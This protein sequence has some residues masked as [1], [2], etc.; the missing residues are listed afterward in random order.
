M[1]LVKASSPIK[2]QNEKEMMMQDKAQQRIHTDY[3][4]NVMSKFGLYTS[5]KTIPASVLSEHKN[6]VDTF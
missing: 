3:V 1:S 6:Q 5:A 4:H 2:V